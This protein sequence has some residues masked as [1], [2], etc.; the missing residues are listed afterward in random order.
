MQ[1]PET[2]QASRQRVYRRRPWQAPARFLRAFGL[3]A[4]DPTAA[5]LPAP[6]ELPMPLQRAGEHGG[7]ILQQ[8]E[9]P[10]APPGYVA[11][12]FT[13]LRLAVTWATIAGLLGISL[14]LALAVAPRAL[15]YQSLV[16]HGG[17][18]GGE[19]PNGSLV[20]TRQIPAQDVA[21]GEVILIQET[22]AAGSSAPKIHRVESLR[23]DGGNIAVRT[24]G[25]ANQSADPSEYILPDQISAPVI[26]LL[27]VGRVVGFVATPTGWTFFVL[28][29]AVLAAAAMIYSIWFPGRPTKRT[30][31]PNP[32]ARMAQCEPW[33][34][35]LLAVAVSG[36]LLVPVAVSVFTEAPGVAGNAFSS[37]TLNAPTALNASGGASVDLSWTAT[38]DTYATG[39]RVY[40]STTSGSGYAQIVQ[41]TPRTTASYNDAPAAGTYYYVVRA[42]YQS[43]ESVNSNEVSATVP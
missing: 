35:A 7:T 33:I 42:Y 31:G 24:R 36:A 34:G 39:H 28:L 23:S 9:L 1:S 3:A 18:M 15:G 16:V 19:M 20:L 10:Q 14:V 37:D 4:A 11:R 43:W 17:S 29:P 6:A 22:T 2:Q 40:R 5:P 13:F 21:V 32:V 30:S 27:Y 12:F 25:D 26:T 8:P 41:I 38:S